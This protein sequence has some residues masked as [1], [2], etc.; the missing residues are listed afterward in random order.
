M[1]DLGNSRNISHEI[2]RIRDDLQV[3]C[4]GLLINGGSICLGRVFSNPI[5]VDTPLFEY[6]LELRVCLDDVSMSFLFSE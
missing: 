3:N 1:T 2:E 5:C 6:N 4:F